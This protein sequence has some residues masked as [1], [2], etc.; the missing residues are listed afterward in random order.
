MI[1]FVRAG[2]Q[3]AER[4]DASLRDQVAD[5]LGLLKA[6]RGGVANGPARLLAGLQVAV[7]QQV[8]ERRNDVGVNNG[9]DLSRVA[10]RDVGDGPTRLLADAILVRAEEGQ[11]AGE[12]RCS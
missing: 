12:G 11:K 5:L 10:G 3:V 9:L 7:G 4:L 1:L 2:E 8:D 6:A